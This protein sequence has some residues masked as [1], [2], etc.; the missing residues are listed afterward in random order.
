MKNPA[1]QLI[2]TLQARGQSLAFAESITGGLAAHKLTLVKG[3]SDVLMGGLTCYNAGLKCRLLKIPKSLIDTH[4]AESQQVTDKMAANLKGVIN[5][6]VLAAIT[7]LASPGGSETKTKPVGTVF[8]SVCYKGK[9]HRQ[10]KLFKG[11]P[12][13]IQ[14]RAC[15]ALYRFILE[16]IK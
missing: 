5:A 6:D 4:T 14:T 15:L 12:L 7:G 11:T 10:R 16:V 3:S 1:N 8:M 13:Q 9:L 2:K